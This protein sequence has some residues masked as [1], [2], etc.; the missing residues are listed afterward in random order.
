M[1]LALKKERGLRQLDKLS[2][3]ADSENKADSDRPGT[4]GWI[5][6]S[7]CPEMQIICAYN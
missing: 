3:L 1:D 2:L 7:V 6:D 5:L 4:W